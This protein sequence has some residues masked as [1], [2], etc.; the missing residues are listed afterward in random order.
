M[1]KDKIELYF[2]CD[3]CDYFSSLKLLLLVIKATIL[4]INISTYLAKNKKAKL[5]SSYFLELF[6]S[7]A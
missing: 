2:I 1:N 6:Y 7:L 3:H 5:Q 4:P